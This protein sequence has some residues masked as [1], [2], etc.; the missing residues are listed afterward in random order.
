MNDK[1]IL[2]AGDKY[3]KQGKAYS[4]SIYNH[5]SK[6]YEYLLP[7]EKSYEESSIKE[8]LKKSSK[9]YNLIGNDIFCDWLGDYIF[10]VWTGKLKIIKLNRITKE[11]SYF[12]EKT[13]NYIQPYVTPEIEKAYNQR[14]NNLFFSFGN[15][16]SFV[17][18][19]FTMNSG[20]VGVIYMGAK[21][22][23]KNLVVMLQIYKT[24]GEFIKEVELLNAQ[25][26]NYN[27][28]YYFFRKDKDLF[29]ILD[30]ETSKDFDQFYKI[31]EYRIE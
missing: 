14:K 8:F 1:E 25:A 6:K 12:G 26:S 2:L 16:M 29:Y 28:L 18:Y 17:R 5:V 3:D 23:N 11:I 24:S 31:H 21:K 22:K 7:F 13:G 30:T 10:H 20:H 27:E 9:K 4:I 15:N 19:L